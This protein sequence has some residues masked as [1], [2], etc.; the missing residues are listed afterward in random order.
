MSFFARAKPKRLAFTLIE[1]LVVIAII[2]VLIGLLLPAVQKVREAASR[3]KCTNNLKQLALS[4]HG[5][6]DAIGTMPPGRKYDIWD[7]FTWS[8]YVLPYLEQNAVYAGYTVISINANNAYTQSGGDRSP[9][10]PS[11]R[12]SRE[13]FIPTF[14][15]PSDIKT[16]GELFPISDTWG[17]W[18]GSYRGCTGS[19]DMYGTPTTGNVYSGVGVFGIKPNQTAL[20][21]SSKGPTLVNILDGTSNT[22]MFSEGVLPNVPGWGGPIGAIIY[23]NMGGGLYSNSLVPNSSAQDQLIGPCPTTQGDTSYNLP[24]TSIAGNNSN[25]RS[26]VNA[27]A[28][29]RSRHSGGVN[30]ALADGSVRFIINSID[31]AAWQAAGTRAGG[32]AVPLN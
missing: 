24:C 22:V 11:Q 27:Q 3:M 7:S 20:D 32:E 8:Q 26:G 4:A 19:G 5:Y 15:C 14:Q 17:N 30:A 31:A 29:A 13:T 28:G 10:G 9:T 12:A 1:L 25:G 23:G 21:G 16:G 18:R 2:A 6:H